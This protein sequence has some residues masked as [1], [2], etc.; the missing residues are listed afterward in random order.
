MKYEYVVFNSLPPLL[1]SIHASIPY[2]K[3]STDTELNI[4]TQDIVTWH[5]LVKLQNVRATL[6]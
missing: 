5:E 3:Y 6:T 1:A 4:F 2:S